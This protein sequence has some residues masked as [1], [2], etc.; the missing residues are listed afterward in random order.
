[1]VSQPN[2]TLL[3]RVKLEESWGKK[4]KKEENKLE[5]KPPYSFVKDMT[6]SVVLVPRHMKIPAA[7]WWSQRRK[8]GSC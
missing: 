4:K 8:G 2:L 6:Q 7:V 5:K 1:M 3:C